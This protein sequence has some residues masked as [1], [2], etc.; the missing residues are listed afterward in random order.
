MR[1]LALIFVSCAISSAILSSQAREPERTVKANMITSESNPRLWIELPKHVRYLGGDRW[2]LYGVADCEVH[3]F[4]EADAHQ[5]VRR[6]YWVQFEGYLPSKPELKYD[7]ASNSRRTFD[8]MDFY[9]KASFGPTDDVPKVGSDQEHVRQLIRAGGY[10]MPPGM[11]N[12]R[13]VHLPDEQKR[14]ELMIIYAEDAAFTG[15][16]W[17]DLLPSGKAADRWPDIQNTLEKRAGERIVFHQV[18]EK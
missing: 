12:V 3:V 6:M 9:V 5:V 18:R 10:T 16:A 17:R 13:L 2:L 8:G 7:Y 11:L 14:K 15:V 1:W 4:V